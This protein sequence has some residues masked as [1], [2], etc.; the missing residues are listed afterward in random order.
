MSASH[1]NKVMRLCAEWP[2]DQTKG[3]RELATA[4]RLYVSQEMEKQDA[5]TEKCDA[6][7][8]SLLRIRT[9]HYLTGFGFQCLEELEG[10]KRGI[11]ATLKHW[12]T[13]GSNRKPE[14]HGD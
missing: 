12:M 6:L 10:V 4:L 8:E 9:N 1:W 3:G 2:V 13:G 11:F 5:D 14:G 7:H